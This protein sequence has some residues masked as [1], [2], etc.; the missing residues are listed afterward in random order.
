[1]K[2]G[3]MHEK[4]QGPVQAD[5]I[6][7][8]DS[9]PWCLLSTIYPY[10]ALQKKEKRKKL[11]AKRKTNKQTNARRMKTPKLTFEAK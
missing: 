3:G 5:R 10:L 4:A 9:C 8:S 11:T 1:M 2:L 6:A 7:K